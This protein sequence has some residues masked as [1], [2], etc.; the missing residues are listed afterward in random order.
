MT[1]TVSLDGK[2]RLT[3]KHDTEPI[4][5][6]EAAV[7]GNIE[8][9]LFH[10]GLCPDPFY[11]DN[12]DRMR[13]FEFYDWEYSRTFT[14][15]A[16]FS[17]R[18]EF[19][20]DGIDGIAEL[21]LNGEL[22]GRAENS[23]IRHTF[24]A[25]GALRRG[26]EN[27]LTIH[28][29]SPMSPHKNRILDHQ[30]I[31]H[32]M[33]FENRD[34]RKPA[35]EYGWDIAPRLPLGGIWKPCRL[36]E[37]PEH[38][39][40]ACYLDPVFPSP[41]AVQI[42]FSY[43][44]RTTIPAWDR[45]LIELKLTCGDSIFAHSEKVWFTSGRFE[46]PV[47][48]PKLWYP[49]GYGEQNLYDAEIV[50][51]CDGAEL[52]R[53]HRRF[54]IRKVRLD[55]DE[56]PENF[57]FHFI[58]NDVPFM[59]KGT[60]HVPLDALHSR[61]RERLPRFLE[62]LRE[63]G[64]NMVR[65]W[66]GG[67]YESQEFYDFCDEHGILVWQDFM[68][69]CAVYPSDDAFAEKLRRECEWAIPELRQ[70][71]AIVLWAGDNEV[72][73]KIAWSRTGMLPEKYR[74]TREVIPQ[75]LQRLDP[76]RPYLPS[77]PY[78]SPTVWAKNLRHGIQGQN[79]CPEQHVWGCR[80]F[81]KAPFYQ[82]NNAA[83]VSESGFHGAPCAE[84]IREFISPEHLWP[85]TGDPEWTAHATLYEG[86]IRLMFGQIMEY[87]GVEPENLEEF[88][89]LSQICQA[90]AKKFFLENT[91]MQKWKKSGILWWNL[92]DCWPQFS[93]SV[94]DYYF[95]K[96]LAFDYI[97]NSQQDI[98]VVCGEAIDWGHRIVLCND[99]LRKL[100]GS[101]RITDADT[102]ESLLEATFHIGEN[103]NKEIGFVRSPRS[104]HRLFLID[105]NTETGPGFN[106]YTTG[107][108]PFPVENYRRWIPLIQKRLNSSCGNCSR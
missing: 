72:D 13:K 60:N 12:V 84:S 71:P 30:V 7:P 19:V 29:T 70:H 92:L 20:F 1:R 82:F 38:E 93:D 75:V 11:A 100:H 73:M 32:E 37:A 52:I 26:T 31:A 16:D 98:L 62:L 68:M 69:A 63:S 77:S 28:L 55:Y 105:W 64:C 54:G 24:P 74:P 95:R 107:F 102:G 91:R 106:F 17:D 43:S 101:C 86:R 23:F 14:V 4:P 47:A 10:A 76:N 85:G 79:F 33:S 40:L 39:L 36:R 53:E 3:G 59:A 83:F 65:V 81:A 108:P 58:I 87:F 27:T 35:H 96:K 50:I 104:R 56:D 21:K 94:V 18:A 22:L 89:F 5:E 66:G 61:D 34:V 6:F 78:Y 8:L 41:D 2:W 44:F 90:E 9:D 45:F 51:S 67:V 25:G 49:R 103:I 15:P 97:R 80:D 88:V 57:R 48:D 42:A 46:F 99:T